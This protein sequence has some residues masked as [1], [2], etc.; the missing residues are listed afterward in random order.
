MC[1]SVDV[2]V[3]VCVVMMSVCVPVPG[4]R[5]LSC[6]AARVRALAV[7]CVCACVRQARAVLLRCASA[8]P[9][10]AVRAHALLGADRAAGAVRAGSARE[11][12]GPSCA[13]ARSST[14]RAPHSFLTHSYGDK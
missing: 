3:C 2:C 14:A 1:V 11:W 7:P 5:A 8:R 4:E 12:R 10:G 9:G 13:C 6:C